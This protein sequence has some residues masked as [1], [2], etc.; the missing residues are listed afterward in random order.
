M[1]LLDNNEGK[2]MKA[3]NSKEDLIEAF[4]QHQHSIKL[5]EG[6]VFNENGERYSDINR[7]R[8]VSKNSVKFIAPKYSMPIIGVYCCN[9]IEKFGFVKI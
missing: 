9:Y 7:E 5:T 2:K 1:Y 3:F 8:E 4:A 6:G